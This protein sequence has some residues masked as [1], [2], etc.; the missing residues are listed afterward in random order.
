MRSPGFL[1]C[2]APEMS[3]PD[4]D[5][6]EQPTSYRLEE[7]RKRGEVPKST[8][9]VGSVVMGVFAVVLVMTC[10]WVASAFATATRQMISL[11][12]NAPALDGTLKGWVSS[13]YAPVWQSL[14]PI[15]L[16]MLVAAVVA[17]VV[18]TGPVFTT[19]PFKPDF[20]R[21]SPGQALKRVFSMRTVWE[22]GKVT[23]KALL[24]AGIV[25]L[26]VKHGR[27][28]AEAAA[29]TLPQKAGFL[30]AAAFSKASL[31]VLLV[32]GLVAAVD[33]L[34]TRREFTK[35]MRMSRRELRDEVK[36][37]DGDPA[38]KSKQRQQIR[39]LLK[40]TRALSRVQEADVILTNPTHVAVALRYRPGQML[41]PV[42]LAKGAGVLSARIRLLAAK[43]RVPVLRSPRLARALYKECEIDGAVPVALFGELAPLYRALWAAR[44]GVAP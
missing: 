31:Y 35:R 11:A 20:K 9:V 17:N 25:A 4:Q 1:R 30:A 42:V 3:Q 15:I 6:T 10:G 23:L 34:F 38:V 8:D 41:A 18:Q 24:L 27:A 7:A 43:H 44:Q 39:E 16:G 33:L 13:T 37:R 22:L 12:G 26:F 21:M 40:K 36:S 5:K 29:A 19:H 32:L 2:W 14:T 28:L